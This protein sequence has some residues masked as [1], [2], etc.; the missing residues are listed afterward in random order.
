MATLLFVD[1][2][3]VTWYP[4]S[5]EQWRA[6]EGTWECP[7][8]ARPWLA[9][10]IPTVPKNDAAF[11]EMLLVHRPRDT[12]W[13]VRSAHNHGEALTWQ[14][15]AIL[16]S[17]VRLRRTVEGGIVRC[18]IQNKQRNAVQLGGYA[19]GIVRHTRLL[20]SNPPR[21]VRAAAATQY[22]LSLVESA[23]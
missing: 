18:E 5:R 16:S 8:G 21:A 2:F 1:G 11:Q 7:G 20:H 19:R 15:T 9:Q 10:K 12:R 22:R 6:W 17:F 13:D 14:N 4:Q 3:V 23:S